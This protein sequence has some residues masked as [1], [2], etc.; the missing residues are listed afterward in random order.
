ME[1]WKEKHWDDVNWVFTFKK[2]SQFE[3]FEN[4]N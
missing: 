4:W 2:Y 3:N 1:F